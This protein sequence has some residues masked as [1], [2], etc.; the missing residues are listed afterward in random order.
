MKVLIVDDEKHVREAILLLIP[1]EEYKISKVFESQNVE[2]AKKV[3]EVEKPDIIFLDMMLANQTGIELLSWIH[4]CGITSK[5][6]VVSGFN[7]FHLVRNTMRYNGVDYILKPIDQG[8]I[9]NAL[10]KAIDAW[11][12]DEVKRLENQ[13]KD[14]RM[15]HIEPIYLDKAL[16]EYLKEPAKHYTILQ[17]INRDIDVNNGLIRI[18][19]LSFQLIHW[20]IHQRFSTNKDLLLFS[21]KNLCNEYLSLYG[22][23][24]AFQNWNNENEIVILFWNQFD[25]TKQILEGINQKIDQ[26]LGSHFFFSVGKPQPL[27]LGISLSY[28]DA[29]KV[30]KSKLNLKKPA[31]FI[32]DDSH[33]S[34]IENET[35]YI[36]N[37]EKKLL[38]AMKCKE[39]YV[40]KSITENF[41]NEL[42]TLQ[43]ITLNHIE[44]WQN[45]L[46]ILKL[47]YFKEFSDHLKRFDPQISFI[48]M[49]DS[50]QLLIEEWLKELKQSFILLHQIISK[51]NTERV[52]VFHEIANYIRKNYHEDLSL[53]YFSDHFYLS[54]EHI[55][56]KFKQEFGTN[57]LDFVIDVRMEK[58]K[59]LLS[60][61]DLRVSD[62][63][64]MVGYN[65]EKYFYKVFKKSIGY[66]PS[67]FRNQIF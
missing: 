32:F 1:W 46:N 45:E 40:I 49:N 14:L 37:Y 51:N 63:C 53:Q 27:P 20:K 60:D 55:S 33:S 36:N 48:L 23:G 26:T 64:K 57:L 47:K 12:Q 19:I 8:E 15:Q 54:R 50:G 31:S 5:V 7:D 21:I 34:V 29:R 6:I 30:L 56:R 65:D 44:I 62:I 18:A 38:F 17:E 24:Y 43:A 39:D 41:T 10:E 4:E 2:A 42:R 28:D 52:N 22:C 13:S 11:K 3:I 9:I 25:H 59:A 16:S 58:A 67:Q 66:S 61:H 35:I